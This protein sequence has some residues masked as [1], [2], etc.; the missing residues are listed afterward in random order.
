MISFQ[1]ARKKILETVKDPEI[2]IVNLDEGF[3]YILAENILADRDYPPFNRSA[4][5]G[6]AVRYEDLEC[7]VRTFNMAGE[8]YAGDTYRNAIHQNECIKIMTGAPVPDDA[9]V[10]I[11]VEETK[12]EGKEMIVD[13]S[14]A[15]LQWM[16]I[17]RKGEDI[18]KG[19]I[20]VGKG[21][22]IDHMIAGGAAVAGK[23]QL[24]VYKRPSVAIISTG[25]EV[26]PVG[27]AVEFYQIRNSNAYNL[28]G[29]LSYLNIKP[30]FNELVKDDKDQLTTVLKKVIDC[31]VIILSGGVSMGDA[32]FVPEILQNL[33]IKNVFHK[34]AIKPGKPIWFGT[35]P[36]HG[37]VFGLPGNPLSSQVG[38]K[39]F[40]EPWIIKSMGMKVPEP[41]HLQI[42]TART[43]KGKLDHF[44]PCYLDRELQLSLKLFN[45]SGDISAT[46]TTDGIAHQPADKEKINA[47]EMVDFYPWKHW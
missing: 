31:D 25:D 15:P 12:L 43:K 3:G 36:D 30:D 17:S 5:D 45:G 32:D 42:K 44:F 26:M 27:K 13:A 33:G 34:S 14:E 21:S 10:V 16:N 19:E 41:F 40:A 4:M 39:L 47:G 29:L 11:K 35:K 24:A 23:N 37:V 18:K 7:G 6:Y 9:D 46:V 8:V 1:D 2:K 22:M 28:T 20:Y 38:Y